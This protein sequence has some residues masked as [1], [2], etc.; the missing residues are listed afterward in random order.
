MLEGT[1]MKKLQNGFKYEF[2]TVLGL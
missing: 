2:D 1:L